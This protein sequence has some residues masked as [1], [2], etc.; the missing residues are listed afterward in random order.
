VLN[1]QWYRANR[2]MQS[3]NPELQKQGF[4]LSNAV[5]AAQR[6]YE[7]RQEAQAIE[8]EAA[9][10]AGIRAMGEQNWQIFSS[11]SDDLRNESS[12]YLDQR[13]SW[14]RIRASAQ[15]ATAAGDLAL[16][17]NYMKLL[18]PTSVVREGEFATAQN[19]GSVPNRVIALYN[20]LLNG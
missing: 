15:N 13:A 10:V 9:E 16:I 6:E 3:S 17:F 4:E 20:N 2:L 14:G 12:A 8:A 18:D 5:L 7:V 1:A 19:S 11:L